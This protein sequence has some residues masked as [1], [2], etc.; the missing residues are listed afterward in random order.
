MSLQVQFLTL[1][2]MAGSGAVLGIGYD[3]IEVLAREFRLR[4]WTTAMMDVGYWLVATLFVFQVLVYANDGQVRMF[5]FIGLLAGVIIYSYMLSRVVRQVV[6]WVISLFM[7][8]LQWGIHIL[9][10]LLVKPLLYVYRLLL[11][12]LGFMLSVTIFLGL[13]MIQYIRYVSKWIMRWF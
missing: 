13:T 3:I 6:T 2:L 11:N 12:I 8:V 7:R 5:V 9:H 10:V 4:R 1:S